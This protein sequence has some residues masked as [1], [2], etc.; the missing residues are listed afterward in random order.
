M[1]QANLLTRAGGLAAAALTRLWHS[2]LDV[3]VVVFDSSVDCTADN[4]ARPCIYVLWHE[5]ILA[6]I[7]SWGNCNISMLTS[8]HRDAQL[9]GRVG[10]HLGFGVIRGSTTRGGITA[11]REMQRVGRFN[12]LAITPDGPQG[13]RRTMAPGAIYLASRLQIPVVC[14]GIGF[15]RPKRLYTWDRFALPRAFSRCRVILGTPIQPP[16]KLSREG[17]ED[18]RA[19]SERMLQ[20]LT[21]R[22]EEWAASGERLHGQRPARYWA[23]GKALA[24]QSPLWHGK[25]EPASILEST[26]VDRSA[27]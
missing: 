12:S 8:R 22:A 6:P 24:Y 19:H 3:Q 5:Y 21:R 25:T 4:F 10:T 27:A 18:F 26:L 13:P 1:D 14:V 11:L 16:P 17:I 9:L 23:P 7:G 20:T 15:D 2:T